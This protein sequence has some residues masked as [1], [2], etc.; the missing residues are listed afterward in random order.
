MKLA[1][2]SPL[3]PSPSGIADYVAETLPALSERHQVEVVTEDPAVDP[4]WSS[5]VPVRRPGEET[6]ADLDVYHVGNSP[7]HAYVYR[8]ALAR[9]GVAVLHDWNLHYLLLGETVERGDTEPY[10]REMR[11]AY[12]ATGTLVA[13]QVSRA[14]GG[15]M[16]PALFPLNDRILESSL[17]VVALSRRVAEQAARRLPDRPVLHLPHHVALPGGPL[18]TR[19]EARAALGLPQDALIVTAP[20]LA[21]A[22][23]RLE[24]AVRI[25]PR[26]RAQVP[27]VKLVIA[28]GVDPKLPLMA[29]IARA[30]VVDAVTVTGRLE[31]GDFIRHL[32]AA[33]VV[34]ALRFPSF[35]EMSGA[36]VRAMGV[37]RPV[38]VTAGTPPAEEMPPGTVA[39]VDPGRHEEAELL[40]ILTRLLDDEALRETVGALARDHVQ[41]HHE[42]LGTVRTLESFLEQVRVRKG[43]LAS[44]IAQDRAEPGT[45]LGYLKEEVRWGARDLGLAGVHLGLDELLAELAGEK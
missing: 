10:L 14:L 25:L 40:G 11:R 27:S 32:V 16:L 19:A 18:P 45:L 2:W 41:T 28:G 15:E 12:G 44:A 4:R 20:G 13:R 7:A 9:P 17:G 23:K 21:T 43:A 38:L 34:L 24:T 39:P 8:A 26:L 31:L 22:A 36:L 1:I 30:G 3:P 5:L 29:W 6:P 33:D 35:G 37:G 42:L